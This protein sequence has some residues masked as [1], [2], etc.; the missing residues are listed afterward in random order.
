MSE[1]VVHSN[2]NNN[3]KFILQIL[4]I[5]TKYLKDKININN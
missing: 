5:T 3:F 4:K 1:D 2:E